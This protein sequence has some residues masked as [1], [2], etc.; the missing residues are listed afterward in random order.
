MGMEMSVSQ[1]VGQSVH[2]CG[3]NWNISTA[4]GCTDMEFGADIHGP[5]R[6]KPTENTDLSCIMA[7]WMSSMK[8][9][10]I[11]RMDFHE[12]SYRS[13]W[14]PEDESYPMILVILWLFPLAPPAGWRFPFGVKCLCG[15]R[16]HYHVI[17]CIHGPRFYLLNWII[18]EFIF[19]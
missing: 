14:S 10:D 8:C 3:H 5:E 12:L 18:F 19:D 15:C 13:A 9:L 11:Y 7:P 1:V 17:W 6:I 16:I 4:I 2:H